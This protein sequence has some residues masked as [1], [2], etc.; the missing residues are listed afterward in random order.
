MDDAIV[1]NVQNLSRSLVVE[2]LVR[3]QF[4]RLT[5]DFDGSVLSTKGHTQG[6][7]LLVSTKLRK[8]P[9]AIIFYFAPLP[10]LDRIKLFYL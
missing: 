2:A 6:V 5:L 9:G 7:L 3:E 8:A 1:D 10:R 4:L